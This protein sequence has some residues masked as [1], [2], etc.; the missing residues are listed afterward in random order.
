M[1]RLNSKTKLDLTQPIYIGMDVHKKKYSISFVHCNQF[2]RRVTIEATESALEKLLKNYRGYSLHSVYEAGF[3]G[4]HLHY[5][6]L[7]F[8]VNNIVAAPNKLPVVSGDKVKTDPRDSLKLATFLSKDLLS[9]ISVPSKELLNLRQA[10]RTRNQLLKKK[11]RCTSQV[12]AILIQQGIK[13]DAVGLSKKVITFIEALRLPEIIK[14]SVLIHIETYKF[15]VKQMEE[16][17][18]IS[19]KSIIKKGDQ[20]NYKLLTSIP[21]VGPLTA[22]ALLYEIGDWSRFKNKKQISAFLGLTPAEYSSGESIRQGRITGQGNPW[23]RS[24]LVEASWQLI[25]KDPAMNEAF[26][27]IAT[28]AKGRKKAIVAIAR[29]L[30]CRMHSMIINQQ[31]YQFGLLG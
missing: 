19:M 26:N 13:I 25:R 8:G 16:I 23:L 7:E 2:I 3:C 9:T 6:L 31:Q 17:E 12:K 18:S 29:K 24:L 22:T 1:L 20:N 27:R 14:A 30:I 4:F 28:Q 21:G 11:K 5:F 15:I 10:L